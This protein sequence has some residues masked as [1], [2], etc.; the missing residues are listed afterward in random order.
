MERKKTKQPQILCKNG[1][2]YLYKMSDND[3]Y[4]LCFEIQNPMI[5]IK[6]LLDDNIYELITK[7]NPDFFEEFKILQEYDDN[8]KDICMSFHSF[9]KELGIQKKTMFINLK[10]CLFSNEIHFI[11]KHILSENNSKK[12]D[13]LIFCEY[14]VGIWVP[15]YLSIDI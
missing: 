4:R 1:G 12:H 2:V 14:D 11:G 3:G 6:N 7:L 9:G 13:I 10:K 15:R 8:S 5:N